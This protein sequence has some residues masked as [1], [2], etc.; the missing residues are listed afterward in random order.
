MCLVHLESRKQPFIKICNSYFDPESSDI[1]LLKRWKKSG[2]LS[3]IT[4][5]ETCPQTYKPYSVS[6]TVQD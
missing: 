3:L 2:Y 6:L 4:H 1:I 5:L